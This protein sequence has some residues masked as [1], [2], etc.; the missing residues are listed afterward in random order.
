MRVVIDNWLSPGL[1]RA[2]AETWPDSTSHHW[3]AYNDRNSVKL[4]SRS[5]AGIPL[6]AQVAIMEMAK[7]DVGAL[8][9]VP[10]AFPDLD[11]LNGA[12][13]HQMNAGGRLGLHLDAERHPLRAWKRVASGV[14]YLEACD[15]GSLEFC[16]HDGTVIERVEPRFNR[17]AL[18]TCDQTWHRV[19]EC[20]SRRRS[21]CLF[22]WEQSADCH[23]ASSARFE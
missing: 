20:R 18:F 3:H 7:I 13:L 9:G 4:A 17:L 10:D 8:L 1:L 15:G 6:A 5:W 22:W 2:V 16:E 11:G 23:G 19:T 21:I 12:G 14:L